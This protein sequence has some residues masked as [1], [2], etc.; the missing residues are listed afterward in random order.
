VSRWIDLGRTIARPSGGAHFHFS[1]TDP[2]SGEV[3]VDGLGNVLNPDQQPFA[4]DYLG[5]IN[6]A[7]GDYFSGEE[8]REDWV[9]PDAS[10]VIEFQ[11]GDAI[12]PGSREVDE[13]N[14]TSWTPDWTLVEKR[15]FVRWRVTFDVAATGQPIS[16]STKHPVM[17]YFHLDFD[18]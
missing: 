3:L 2:L 14:A 9:P 15:Q 5:R 13:P 10:V 4:I 18:F 12:V 11:A 7:T 17:Q 16:D 6:P 1:G 8:P